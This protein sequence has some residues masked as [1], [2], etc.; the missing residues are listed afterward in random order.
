M[1][2]FHSFNFPCS[3]SPSPAQRAP[4]A[5]DDAGPPPERTYALVEFK[6]GDL[7]GY[8]AAVSK[9][10]QARW[11]FAA[12]RAATGRRRRRRRRQAQ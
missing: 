6:R 3:F 8:L 5:D 7:H 12:F 2:D 4:A 9:F 11:R 1:R 10:G